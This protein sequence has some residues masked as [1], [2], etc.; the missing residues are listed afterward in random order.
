M[1]HSWNALLLTSFAR[2]GA[3]AIRV[4]ENGRWKYLR[5]LREQRFAS[6]L[7]SFRCVGMVYR[8]RIN[9]HRRTARLL[10]NEIVNELFMSVTFSTTSWKLWTTARSSLESPLTIQIGN[11]EYL[12]TTLLL[13]SVAASRL[14]PNNPEWKKKRKIYIHILKRSTSTVKIVD[15]YNFGYAIF[16]PINQ[17]TDAESEIYDFVATDF[18]RT[19]RHNW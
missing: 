1:V 9:R 10:N 11:I 14:S 18:V 2:V 12:K 17:I 8:E 19:I 15:K 7:W 13:R 16:L 4:I 3:P 6:S 5:R